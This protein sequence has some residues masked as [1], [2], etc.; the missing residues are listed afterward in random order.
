MI[1]VSDKWLI[2]V[3]H[4]LN[5]TA[6][7]DLIANKNAVK[8]LNIFNRTFCL[9]QSTYLITPH[10]IRAPPPPSGAG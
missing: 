2:D 4:K 1:Q 10:A 6:E 8:I 3:I 9:Q 7:V 5:G